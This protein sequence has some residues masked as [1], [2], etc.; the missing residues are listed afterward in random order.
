MERH[1]IAILFPGQGAFYPGALKR[2]RAFHQQIDEVLAEIDPV[3]AASIG[4]RFLR[5]SSLQSR[6]TFLN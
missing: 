5:Y 4:Q 1:K 3:A 2:A 6:S